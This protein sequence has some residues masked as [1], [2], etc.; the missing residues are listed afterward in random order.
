M[1]WRGRPLTSHEVVINT[2]AATTTR[3]GLR[4]HSELDADPAG[5]ASRSACGESRAVRSAHGT[6][7]GLVSST[8]SRWKKSRPAA[9]CLGEHDRARYSVAAVAWSRPALAPSR[10]PASRPMAIIPMARTRC[11]QLSAVLTGTKFAELFWS[12]TKP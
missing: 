12:I 1:N 10:R 4:V 5:N 8:V 6:Q 2:I 7:H 3:T 9:H 11:N